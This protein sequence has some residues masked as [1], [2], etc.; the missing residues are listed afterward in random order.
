MATITTSRRP[1]GA[2]TEAAPWYGATVAELAFG[3][4]V[5]A[6][7]PM[8]LVGSVVVDCKTC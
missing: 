2:A 7:E 6:P 4:T 3:P 8:G 1:F 5:G